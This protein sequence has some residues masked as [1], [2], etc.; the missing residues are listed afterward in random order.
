MQSQQTI[1]Q[2]K[3]VDDLVV[4]VHS[5]VP[6]RIIRIIKCLGAIVMAQQDGEEGGLRER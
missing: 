6:C 3:N 1:M 5:V 2:Q 4:K